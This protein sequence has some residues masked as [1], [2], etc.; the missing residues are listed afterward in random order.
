VLRY[1]NIN[2]KNSNHEHTGLE[3]VL[4]GTP[5]SAHILGI[6]AN[7][8]VFVYTGVNL[9][10]IAFIVLLKL[11]QLDRCEASILRICRRDTAHTRTSL[12]AKIAQVHFQ[13]ENWTH[14]A[15][16]SHSALCVQFSVYGNKPKVFQ[17]IR[18]T[19]Y[20]EKLTVTQWLKIILINSKIHY[21]SHKISLS[22]QFSRHF[23]VTHYFIKLIL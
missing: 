21:H 1:T 2:A 20:S 10:S 22:Y 6:T 8:L 17:L 5:K 19:F 15:G 4:C 7:I 11:I 23:S 14:K 18:T 16:W 12:T 13:K 3:V 9:A